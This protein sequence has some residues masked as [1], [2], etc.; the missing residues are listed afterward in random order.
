MATGKDPKQRRSKKNNRQSELSDFEKEAVEKLLNG[1]KLGGKDG[2]LAPL[3]KRIVEASIEGE[4]DDHL[5]EEK[6][7]GKS[8]RRGRYI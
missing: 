4:L 6:A 3:I 7:S 8:N 1:D 2:I 5:Y